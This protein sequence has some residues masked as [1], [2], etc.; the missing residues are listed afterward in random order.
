MIQSWIVMLWNLSA[1]ES[2]SKQIKA[3]AN[4]LLHHASVTNNCQRNHSNW[5]GPVWRMKGKSTETWPRGSF[6]WWKHL[7]CMIFNL[8]NEG[9][10]L[11]FSVDV[12]SQLVD[13]YLD[14][15]WQKSSRIQIIAWYGLIFI[16]ELDQLFLRGHFLLFSAD[17]HV[18]L[19]FCTFSCIQRC[20][21]N[22]TQCDRLVENSH[23]FCL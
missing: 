19:Q 20:Q 9:G 7:Y 17:I 1:S 16:Q 11:N 12:W 18:F 23:V 22:N 21:N 4:L 14:S 15:L 6:W 2:T 5:W 13:F 10:P 8:W 3:L